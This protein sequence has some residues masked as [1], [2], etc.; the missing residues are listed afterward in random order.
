M[1]WKS[2]R[3]FLFLYIIAFTVLSD[4]NLEMDV[5]TAWS[6]VHPPVHPLYQ[7]THYH[8]RANPANSFASMNCCVCFLK[9]FLFL[10][11]SEPFS[12]G[13]LLYILVPTV[14]TV[15]AVQKYQVVAKKL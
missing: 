12:S 3:F 6:G 15:V 10:N 11:F 14:P 9:Y 5:G 13:F 1:R 4:A 7:G 8:E 2:L